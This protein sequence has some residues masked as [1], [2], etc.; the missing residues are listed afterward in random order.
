MSTLGNPSRF[1]GTAVPPEMDHAPADWASDYI[2]ASITL[3]APLPP[4]MP[5]TDVTPSLVA[6]TMRDA[7]G[8]F[9]LSSANGDQ[10]RGI[11]EDGFPPL[12]GINQ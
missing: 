7:L 4:N 11:P 1:A 5:L 9:F 12:D 2:I 6:W 8:Y 10:L 3:A